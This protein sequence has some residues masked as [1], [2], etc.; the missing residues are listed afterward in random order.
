MPNEERTES[1]V[2]NQTIE[3]RASEGNPTQLIGYG[4]VFYNPADE[5]TQ[6]QIADDYIERI[7]PGAFAEAIVNDDVRGLFNHDSNNLLGRT[8][9]STMRLM[10]DAKGLRYEIDV[11]DTQLGQDLL[12]L[13]ERGDLS[14]SSFSFIPV[15]QSYEKSDGMVIRTI[16]KVKLF[17]V[18]PVTFPAYEA[19]TTE[20]RAQAKEII[21]SRKAEEMKQRRTKVRK[22]LMKLAIEK[23]KNI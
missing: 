22:G 2:T 11:P 3:I 5:G 12:K 20:A 16:Q 17:D 4:A 23:V 19:T 10:E 7:A 9:A 15:K 21:N 1:R 13:A 14:G 18:G 8:T 6:Y